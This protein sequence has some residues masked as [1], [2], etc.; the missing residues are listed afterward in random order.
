MNAWVRVTVTTALVL[1]CLDGHAK[2][3]DKCI[4]MLEARPTR[5][6]AT[7]PRPCPIAIGYMPRPHGPVARPTERTPFDAR[8]SRPGAPLDATT[9]DADALDPSGPA[10]HV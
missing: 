7:S 10:L 5:P 9:A 1:T 4:Q 8:L 6:D 2:V 3:A